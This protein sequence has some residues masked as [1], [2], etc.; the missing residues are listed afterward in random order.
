[1]GGQEV[2]LQEVRD[3]IV[4]AGHRSP[5]GT[6]RKLPGIRAEPQAGTIPTD[7]LLDRNRPAGGGGYTSKA[8]RPPAPLESRV[9]ELKRR[10]TNAA[11]RK[12]V[13]ETAITKEIVMRKLWE[14][15]LRAEQAVGG[16]SVANRALELLG[17]ELGLFRDP[18]DRLPVKLDELP[19]ETLAN[20]LAEAEARAAIEREEAEATQGRDAPAPPKVN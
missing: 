17:K 20:M 14:N 2:R 5:S 8:Q 16:S 12:A 15:A 13:E 19:P 18:V 6:H 7:H 11:M 10:I 9:Q 4:I 3:T 1:M